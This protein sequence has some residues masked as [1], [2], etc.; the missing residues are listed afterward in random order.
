MP[1]AQTGEIDLSAWDF[2]KDGIAKLDGEW[3]FYWQQLLQP[4]DFQE[5]IP[6]KDYYQVPNLWNGLVHHGKKITNIGYATFRLIIHTKGDE[7]ILAIRT[8]RMESN[9]NLW[10]NGEKL[11]SYGKVGASKQESVPMWYPTVKYFTATDKPIELVLQVSNFHHKKGGISHSLTIGMPEDLAHKRQN[12]NYF[13]IFLLGVLLITS[14]YHFG[15]Y[16]LRR[17]DPSN[18]YFGLTAFL[19][20]VNSLTTGN[21][22]LIKMFPDF[23]WELMLKSNFISNYLRLVFFAM[24]LGN[25]FKKRISTTFIKWQKYWGFLMTVFVMFTPA[26]IYGYTLI[27]FEVTVLVVIFVL[28]RGLILASLDKNRDAMLSLLGT[29]TLFATAINDILHD[30]LI[31]HT[32]YLVPFG[33]FIFVFFQSLML[34]MRSSRSFTEVEKLSSRLTF[35]DKL[36][37][38]FLE[39]TSRNL[40]SVLEIVATEF[41]ADNAFLILE[42]KGKLYIEAAISTNSQEYRNFTPLNLTETETGR[43]PLSVFRFMLNEKTNFYAQH[44]STHQNFSSD[45]YLRRFAIQEAF[46]LLLTAGKERRGFFY[47]DSQ[48]SANVFTEEKRKTLTLM[49]SQ[50]LSISDNILIYNE[51]T[52][53]NKNLEAKVEHRTREISIK[54]E[55]IIAQRDAI[56]EANATLQLAYDRLDK[57]NR[58]LTNSIK[59]AKKIQKAVF[60]TLEFFNELIPDSFIFFKPIQDLSGDFYWIDR[61]PPQI[62]ADKRNFILAVGDCT[63]HGVP[64][65]LLSIMGNNLLNYAV[66]TYEKT[67]PNAILEILDKGFK[68][69][70]VRDGIDIAVIS[71]QHETKKLHFGGAKNDMYL[72][73][74]KKLI[75]FKSDPFSVGRWISKRKIREV[76]FKNHEI[77]IQQGDVIY[78]FTD[79]YADQFGGKYGRKYMYSALR[80]FLLKISYLPMQQQSEQLRENMRLWQNNYAQIDDMLIIGLKF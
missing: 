42:K 77:N 68:E 17:S 9:Y 24:F 55:E 65:A 21:V 79:G 43:F 31:I 2:Q 34:S 60:P 14:F 80:N 71:Y 51:I 49:N 28:L 4:A 7:K 67:Q 38:R 56:E 62:N 25:L 27:L 20:A 72:I 3:E 74:N 18:L 75:V 10:I 35:L 73:R 1:I 30:M 61:F 44:L 32:A 57:S 19:M 37:N 22:L 76:A 52:E 48:V 58:D 69:R 8:K 26:L 40:N 39:L 16:I 63:G 50:L 13:T 12:L 47:F 59:Y 5:H 64:G 36:K 54:S 66:S 45:S 23:N 33:M 29:L 41:G 78:L 53:L 15:L 11:F 6:R 70:K 46:C